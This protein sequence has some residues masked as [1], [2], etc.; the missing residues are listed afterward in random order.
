MSLESVGIQRIP[1]ESRQG[2]PRSLFNLWFAANLTIADFALGFIPISMGMNFESSIVSIIIGNILGA[3]IVGLSAVMGPRTGYPQMMTT[4][5]SMGRIVMRLFGIINLSNTLGWFVIN[6]ILSV[7]A[8]YL[9]FGVSYF[10]LV[11]LFVLVI[12]IVA[13]LGH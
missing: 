11:P 2:K 12:Y 13:Y 9:I 7:F 1:T 5:N 3:A 8:L 4:T 10:I 6:I